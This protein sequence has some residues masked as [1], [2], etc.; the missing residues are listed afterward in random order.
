ML[1]VFSTQLRRIHHQVQSLLSTDRITANPEAGLFGVGEYYL[2][3]HQY[4][5]A[6]HVFQSY[7][8]HWPKGTY[9]PQA[10]L[11]FGEAQAAMEAAVPD[12]GEE[13]DSVA[14]YSVMSFT[15][16]NNL[17]KLGRYK[18]A[19]KGFLSIIKDGRD[20]EH[21]SYAEFR[22]G[23]SLYHLE[24]YNDATKQL[25]MVIRKY[26][27]H[28]HLA[29]AVYMMGLSHVAMG[30]DDKAL[31]FLRKAGKMVPEGGAL[32]RQIVKKIRDLGGSS[33]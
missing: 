15:E 4:P 5:Q 28:A 21:L 26:P 25:A 20:P 7:L 32:Y 6:S 12:G 17:Y 19:M 33:V 9:A 10:T 27:K 1:Q 31:G 13:R 29:E 23:C 24:K 8:N 16:I 3:E 2:K 11:K 14:D 18:D 22:V 30:D